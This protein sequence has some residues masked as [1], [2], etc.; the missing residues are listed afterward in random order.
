M[1]VH[2]KSVRNLIYTLKSG[3][4]TVAELETNLHAGMAGMQLHTQLQST[5][6]PRFE[7]VVN[8]CL[9]SSMNDANA[10]KEYVQTSFGLV[11]VTKS[12]LVDNCRQPLTGDSL[13][14][15]RFNIV[16]NAFN[17]QAKCNSS[18]PIQKLKYILPLISSSKEKIWVISP[19]RLEIVKSG[20][21]V[22]VEASKPFKTTGQ[23]N[24]SIFNPVPGS[25]KVLLEFAYNEIG[26]TIRV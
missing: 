2:L 20:T 5:S 10:T 22:S 1:A 16:N 14:E 21:V 25:E 13:C 18:Q 23:R 15:I 7:A 8:G 24:E 4:T 6:L 11:Q 9:Y 17:I 19:T 26:I 3:T 12:R